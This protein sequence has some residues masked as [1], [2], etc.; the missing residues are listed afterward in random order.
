M[1][2]ENVSKQMLTHCIE[3]YTSIQN[4]VFSNIDYAIRNF[5]TALVSQRS[6]SKDSEIG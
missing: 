2:T 5:K 6:W 1:K 4:G 3:H